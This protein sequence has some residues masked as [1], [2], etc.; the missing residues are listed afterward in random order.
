MH[1]GRE[2]EREIQSAR[3]EMQNAETRIHPWVNG[4]P[5]LGEVMEKHKEKMDLKDI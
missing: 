5:Q 2:R 3:A 1:K 4:N